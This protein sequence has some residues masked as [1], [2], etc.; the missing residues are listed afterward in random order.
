MERFQVDPVFRRKLAKSI[1][2]YSSW[3]NITPVNQLT[4]TCQKSSI[5]Q[6]AK[7]VGQLI[8]A[9]PVVS[10]T[11]NSLPPASPS[12]DD[13]IQIIY[14]KT[15][16]PSSTSSNSAKSVSLPTPISST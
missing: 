14:E 1:D 11:K 15:N 2:R 5:F 4:T 7:A 9:E 12:S 10:K 16:V 13:E 6:E 8:K 3:I